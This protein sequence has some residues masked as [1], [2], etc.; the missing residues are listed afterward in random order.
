[1][2]SRVRDTL[3]VQRWIFT[4]SREEKWVVLLE[5][6]MCIFFDPKSPILGKIKVLVHRDLC[7]R[8]F[9]VYNGKKKKESACSSQDSS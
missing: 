1:M 8:Q 7:I 6:K 2:G 5:F 9:I 3:L 4:T